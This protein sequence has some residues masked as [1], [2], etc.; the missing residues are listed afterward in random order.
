M[1]DYFASLPAAGILT[2]RTHVAVV[3]V[4]FKI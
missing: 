4:V 3:V 1:P 2:L